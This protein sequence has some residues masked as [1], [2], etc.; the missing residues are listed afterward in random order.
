MLKWVPYSTL[1]RK[2]C[3][4]VLNNSREGDYTTSLASLFQSSVNLTIKV[5]MELPIQFVPVAPYPA[6]G[7]H[8]KDPDPTVLTST[9]QMFLSV[10]KIPSQSSLPQA[11]LS[12]VS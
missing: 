7:H 11:K 2:A 1:C 8:Q 9:L 6:T 5:E 3:R 4:E 10:D 12:Q